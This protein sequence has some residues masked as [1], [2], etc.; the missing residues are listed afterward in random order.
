MQDEKSQLLIGLGGNLPSKFGKPDVTIAKGIER[1]KQCGLEDLVQSHVYE[2]W[3]MPI[4]EQ[5]NFINVTISATTHLSAVEVLN[6]FQQIETE[7]GRE[8]GERWSARTLDIDLIAYG[9]SILPNKEIWRGVVNDPDPA[10]Y[11]EEPVVPHPRMHKRAFV[12]APLMDIAPNWLHPVLGKTVAELIQMP[13][14]Q[15][16]MQTVKKIREKL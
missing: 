2:T 16:E 8:V 15:K 9:N 4:S 7:L 10:A 13:E 5:P 14:I 12:L 6:K 11:L 1:L 3:A